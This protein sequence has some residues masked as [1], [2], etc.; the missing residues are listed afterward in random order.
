[1]RRSKP[2]HPGEVLY[3]DF[4]VPLEL[5]ANALAKILGVPTNR[6]TAIVNGQRAITGDTALRL[7]TAFDMTPEFW[8]NLQSQHDLELADMAKGDEIKKTVRP[9]EAVAA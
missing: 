6:V 4:M 2:I 3:E 1:M 7:G 8:M 9:V 5:S